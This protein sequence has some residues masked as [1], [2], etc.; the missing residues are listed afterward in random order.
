[1]ATTVNWID[2]RDHQD[3]ARLR[4]ATLAGADGQQRRFLFITGLAN[5]S[6]KWNQAL[7]RLGFSASPKGKYLSR[8]VRDGEQLKASTFHSVWPNALRAQMDVDLVR[9]ELTT[10]RQQRESLRE[11]SK[12]ER[13]VAMDVGVVTRLGRN[14]EGDEVFETG[15]GRLLRRPSGAPVYES[16]LLPSP[17]FLRAS[18]EAEFDLCADGFVQSMLLGEVQ[19][20][21]DVDRFLHA[22][23]G[24]E[25]P[26]GAEAQD[27]VSAA[28][29]AAIVR[30]LHRTYETAQDAWG[31]AVRLYEYLP[32]YRG[33]A[34]GRGA[35]P[36]PVSVMAQRLLGDT[37]GRRVVLPNAWDGAAFAFLPR[38][39]HIAAFRGSK[40]L[41][42]KV[43][44]VRQEDVTWGEQFEPSREQGADGLFFNA[45]PQLAPDGSR[46]DY[47]QALA[48]LRGL[49]PDARA[50]LVL[51]AE[52]DSRDGSLDDEA[53]RFVQA[54]GR[55]YDIEAAIQTSSILARGV[56]TQ[57]GLRIIALRNRAPVSTSLQPQQFQ[58]VH[59]WDDLK[60]RV[61]EI[62]ATIDLREAESEGIDVEKAT[63]ENDFQRPYVAFS[64]VGEATTMVPKN[65]QGPLQYAMTQI[66]SAYGPVDAFVER[67]LGFGPNTLGDRFSPEQVDAIGLGVAKLKDERGI[68]IGDETGI[69]KGRIIGAL[70][71]WASKQG[72]DVI[73]VTDRANLFSDLVRDLRDIGEFGRFRPL[74]MNA[75]GALMD[76]FTNEA[77]QA[78]TKPKEMARIVADDVPLSELQCN[79]VFTTYS[80]ISA[81]DSPKADW[82]LNRAPGSLVIVDEAHVAAGSNSNIASAVLELVGRAA[83]VVYSS[84]TW[85]K[86]SDNLHIYSRAFPETINMASLAG[87]MRS[88][89]EPFSEVFS[90]MLASDGAFVRREHD[91]SK[92]EFVVETDTTRTERNNAL[93]DRVAE[94][95]SAMTFLSGDINR[96]V[97]RLNSDTTKHLRA[98]RSALEA[99][100]RGTAALPPEFRGTMFRSSFGAGTVLYQVMR[101]YLSVLNADHVVDLAMKATQENRKPVIVFEDTGEAFVK[102]LIE[103]QVIPGAEGEDATRPTTVRVPT[104]RDLLGHIMKRLGVIGVRQTTLADIG[105]ERNEPGQDDAEGR[106]GEGGE[107]ERAEGEVDIEA[108]L[109]AQ[110]QAGEGSQ[111]LLHELPGVSAEQQEAFKL[112]ITKIMEMIGELPPVPLNAVDV[113]RGRLAEAGLRVSELSGRSVMLDAPVRHRMEPIDSP[114]WAESRSTIVPRK[115]NKALVSRTVWEFNNGEVDVLL[116]NRSAATGTSLHASPRFA[117]QRRR[118]LIE[119]QIPENPTDRIQLYGRVN[120]YDQVVTPRI[121][122]ATTGIFG[123]VRQIM[124]QNKKLARLSANVRSSRDNAAEIKFVPDLLNAVGEDIA[125]HYLSENG[126][127]RSRIG[128]SEEDLEKPSYQLNI[129]QRLTSR[130]PLLRV[131][132]Q[133]V[134]YDDLYSSYDEAI[135]RYEMEGGNPLKAREMDVRA[136]VKSSELAIGMDM[137]GMGSAFDGPV[138]IKQL[139]WEEMSRPVSLDSLIHMVGEGR[140]QLLADGFAVEVLRDPEGSAG[141]HKRRIGWGGVEGIPAVEVAHTMPDVGGLRWSLDASKDPE[142]EQDDPGQGDASTDDSGDLDQAWETECSVP[143]VEVFRNASMRLDGQESDEDEDEGED[144]FDE[145]DPAEASRS[146]TSDRLRRLQALPR[147]DMKPVIDK[148]VMILGAKMRLELAG[149]QFEDVG[150][151]LASPKSNSIQRA[152]ASLRWIQSRMQDIVP[153]GHVGLRAG[154]GARRSEEH[155]YHRWYVVTAIKPPAKGKE[156]QLSRWKVDLLGA[157]AEKPITRTLSSVM[158]EPYLYSSDLQGQLGLASEGVASDNIFDG[159]VMD[160]RAIADRHARGLGALHRF[161]HWKSGAISCEATVLDG[162][163]YMASEW[164]AATK[165]G[166]GVVYSDDRGVRHRAILVDRRTRMSAL[167]HMPIR[168]WSPAMIGE[169]VRRLVGVFGAAPASGVPAQGGDEVGVDGGLAEVRLLTPQTQQSQSPAGVLTVDP[170]GIRGRQE[171]HAFHTNIKTAIN[172]GLVFEKAAF[173]VMPDK[174]VA[175]HAEKKESTRIARALRAQAK[176]MLRQLNP[177]LLRY[178]PEERERAMRALPTVHVSARKGQGS[179]VSLMCTEPEHWQKAVDMLCHGAGLELYVNRRDS[180][181]PLAQQ[182]QTGHFE[183]RLEAAK[184]KRERLLMRADTQPVVAALS[185]NRPDHTNQATEQGP[186]AANEL[187][188]EQSSGRESERARAA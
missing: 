188:V 55:R 19:H 51:A 61:D 1:M 56:G 69:G 133:R 100:T 160:P 159:D 128:L 15:S 179:F 173:V 147:I 23:H 112:G 162:N 135:A 119:L 98:A 156:A 144:A 59:S 40:N 123:E 17:L 89:G 60:S 107:G 32:P 8:L 166:Q 22:I 113:I 39:T 127:I 178:T 129:V 44:Q 120:R 68:I 26:F 84:A 79:I 97:M 169:F 37:A 109:T 75:D 106:A 152:F 115:R 174:G 172:S 88:G 138:Y 183:R 145:V 4:I 103:Q 73:F 181:A 34:R 67:E 163:M 122:I 116:I 12:E 114:V 25:A 184:S 52:A 95:L 30:L 126:G 33:S 16:A 13:S 137:Q 62:I 31:D 14:A 20:N 158:G 64:R 41:A 125:R 82:L 132:E 7:A 104:I 29:D 185:C 186:E 49:N 83:G 140:R 11:P 10:T 18:N 150:A 57:A 90:S 171:S 102:R 148:L 87:T 27:S 70:A 130:V 94:V 117:D 182:V 36:I 77:I 3:K 42:S 85:A 5:T 151:A 118:E 177:G 149:S 164:A 124:M 105:P 157:G 134:V 24:G 48:A 110:D 165:M 76:L 38:G 9:L 121:A 180:S 168:L 74:I 58:V 101:R 170:E 6:P 136:R 93:S 45:D 131:V 86:S 108:V 111:L 66:E 92:I 81:E 91:L 175:F 154:K 21:A 153:G 139:C 65:L 2:L 63:R 72:R 46:R 161:S 96:M 143:G 35:M 187:D 54:L 167:E 141:Q 47:P 146:L 50:V 43:A 99:S 176:A 71:T 53:L 142:A 155:D 80:Q 78:G 28:I